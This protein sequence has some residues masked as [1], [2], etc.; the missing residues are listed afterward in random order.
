[1]TALIFYVIMLVQEVIKNMNL[2]QILKAYHNFIFSDVQNNERAEI[3]L[4]WNGNKVRFPIP[5]AELP[6]IEQTQ[7]NGTFES[8]AGDMS[9]IGTLGCKT[10]SLDDLRC[11]ADASKYSFSK[12]SNANDIIN[13]IRDGRT[14]DKPFRIVITKGAETYVNMLCV[15]DNFS[16]YQ[17]SACDFIIS[18]DCR[19]YVERGGLNV[20]S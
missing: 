10:I 11:P 15:I 14:S 20:L 19:E 8:I 2:I 3:I 9:T 18:F 7:K 1:M 12:G 17:D 16:W 4:E 6:T 5:P 13:L